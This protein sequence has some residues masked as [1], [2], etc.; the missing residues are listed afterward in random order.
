MHRDELPIASGD[1]AN[2]SDG[3]MC[4]HPDEGVRVNGAKVV[5]DQVEYAGQRTIGG[6]RDLSS[7][8]DC[9]DTWT[10]VAEEDAAEVSKRG[11]L[12]EGPRLGSGDVIDE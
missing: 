10:A 2:R 4:R 8:M 12:V 1:L 11:G 3:R 5:K 9:V 6:A 7:G